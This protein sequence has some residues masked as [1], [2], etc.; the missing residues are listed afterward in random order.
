MAGA[1]GGGDNDSGVTQRVFGTF[2]SWL[3]EKESPVFVVATAN[4]VSGLP[5]ELLRKG[6]FDEIFF[7]D[8]PSRGAREEIL[9]IHIRDS[10][11]DPDNFDIARL[12]KASDGFSG[13]ELAEAVK[14]AMFDAFDDGGREYTTED[15][16]LNLD[17]EKSPPLS[18]TMSERITTL[19]A[20][21]E[22]RARRADGPTDETVANRAQNRFSG[23]D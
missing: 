21:A 22:K 4:D 3:Q 13:S 14:S 7:C 23:L 8:L 10:Q 18:K 5:P 20:W 12:S 11:R 19:R 9:R 2:L 1:G 6:R 15:L 17:P 16:L